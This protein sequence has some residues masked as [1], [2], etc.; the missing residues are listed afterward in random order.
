[1]PALRKRFLLDE[2]VALSPERAARPRHLHLHAPSGMTV[3]TCP[4][5]PQNHGVTPDEIATFPS[6]DYPDEAAA[7]RVL[8]NKFPA[9][10]VEVGTTPPSTP[11]L[12]ALDGIGAHEVIVEAPAH[13]TRM[14]EHSPL[15]LAQIL[16]TWQERARDLRQDQRLRQIVLFRNEGPRAGATLEHVHSQLIALPIIAPA[17]RREL[18]GAQRYF[19]EHRVCPFCALI[20]EERQAAERLIIDTPDVVALMPF[21]S[22][23]PFETWLLPTHHGAHFCEAPAETIENLARTLDRVLHAWEL[24]IGKVGFNLVVHSLPFDFA[25]ETYYHWHLEMIPRT[26]QIAGFELGAQMYINPT[27]SEVAARHLRKLLT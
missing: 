4:F 23:V 10:R 12:T 26:G 13:I 6:P 9:L 5:C 25:D 15:H 18:I 1:M 22:R 20:D 8:P 27:A 2:W 11:L 24:A 19:Q 7:I 3:H 16:K 21:G 17:I 14:S